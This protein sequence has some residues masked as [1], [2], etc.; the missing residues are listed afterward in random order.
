MQ[1]GMI[2]VTPEPEKNM[3]FSF[4]SNMFLFLFV[5]FVS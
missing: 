5:F 2:K 3:F 1:T 4:L